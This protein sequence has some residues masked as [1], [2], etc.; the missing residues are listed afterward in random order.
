MISWL[1]K[2][3]PDNSFLRKLFSWGKALSARIYFGDVSSGLILIGV[4]GTDGKTT[5]SHF[6]AQLLE[7]LGEKVALASTEALFIAE[8]KKENSS[9]RTTLNPWELFSFLKKA[10]QSG[11]KYVVIEVSS[12]ALSQGRVF[13]LQFSV[14]ILT[15]LSQEHGNYHP[16]LQEY[17]QTKKKLFEMVMASPAQKKACFLCKETE[18][19]DL[20]LQNIS[21]AYSYSL[22]DVSADFYAI[23]EKENS[24]SL[25]LRY[26]NTEILCPFVGK[27][28]GENFFVALLVAEFFGYSVKDIAKVSQKIQPVPGRLEEVLLPI[29]ARAFIDFAITPLALEKLLRSLRRITPHKI[30]IVFGC[31]GANHDHKKR[32]LMGEIAT[33][34]AD[35]VYI[36]EDET[37]GEEN[38]KIMKEICSGIPKDRKNFLCISDRKEAIEKALASLEEGDTLC[39]TGMGNFKSRYNGKEEIPWSDK[40]VVLNFFYERSE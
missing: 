31:T 10:K 19:F 1:R 2:R 20:F 5:V 17:A 29:Q 39:V 23:L 9:K 26:K 37:Y 33:R 27:Y 6:T 32:P 4:T 24:H 35:C 7:L 40:E 13:G 14:G 3:V 8:D 34:Y 18:F 15:N 38:E 12:H 28:N 22:E 25:V 30:H 36:T 21:P 16:S 11:V